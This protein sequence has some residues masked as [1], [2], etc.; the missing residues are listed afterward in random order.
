METYTI[1]WIQV[2]KS[3]VAIILASMLFAVASN[4]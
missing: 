3:L 1:C 4:I 2:F